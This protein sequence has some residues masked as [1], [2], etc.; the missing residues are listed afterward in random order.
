MELKLGFEQDT[1]SQKL[2]FCLLQPFSKNEPLSPPCD[3]FADGHGSFVG[4]RRA[5]ST[6]GASS[7]LKDDP[8]NETIE[9][10]SSEEIA[11]FDGKSKSDF[12]KTCKGFL[13][14]D[15]NFIIRF[16]IYPQLTS[17]VLLEGNH[18]SNFSSSRIH[19]SIN[20]I[21]NSPIKLVQFRYFSRK[22]INKFFN[23]FLNRHLRSVH[24]LLKNIKSLSSNIF[25]SFTL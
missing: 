15:K 24:K 17:I 20:I 6:M 3:T 23:L 4:N 5:K 10:S 9:E 11:V 19:K 2:C 12:V 21:L 8:I 14:G 7:V 25:S 13:N 18:I 22:Q 1:P 16:H